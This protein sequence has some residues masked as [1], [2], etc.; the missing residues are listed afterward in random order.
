M[1]S[2]WIQHVMS[3]KKAKGCSLK[4]AMKLAKA[5]YKK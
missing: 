2:P 4:E 5:S 3:V 1:L